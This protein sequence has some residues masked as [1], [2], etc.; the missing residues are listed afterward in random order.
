V[1]IPGK[2]R[3][4]RKTA[5]DILFSHDHTDPNHGSCDPN[6]KQIVINVNQSKTNIKKTMLH[7]ALH[8]MSIEHEINLTETQV[9][10]LED[11]VWKLL[12]LNKIKVK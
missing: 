11:A 9:R 5:Y 1:R 7:E 10:K 6:K 4:T 2:I 3:I 8:A 12:N